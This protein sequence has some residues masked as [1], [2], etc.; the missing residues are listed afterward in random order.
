MMV[1]LKNKENSVSNKKIPVIKS[2][3]RITPIH[4][5]METK[6]KI[7]IINN[8]KKRIVT[9]DTSLIKSFMKTVPF[10]VLALGIALSVLLYLSNIYIF[11]FDWKIP[12]I[13]MLIALQI[14]LL[15][16][17]IKSR[18]KKL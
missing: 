15:I 17:A 14:V 13:P 8:R 16:L 3:V 12:F 18:Y 10:V 7:E 1:T 5:L 2:F 4:T 9:T 6:S 11:N